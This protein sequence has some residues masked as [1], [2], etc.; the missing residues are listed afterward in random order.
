MNTT[1]GIVQ[2]LN[3]WT[4]LQHQ[5]NIKT[6]KTSTYPTRA[7]THRNRWYD[8]FS[9]KIAFWVSLQRGIIQ[10][11]SFAHFLFQNVIFFII[12]DGMTGNGREFPFSRFCVE[13]FALFLK[14]SKIIKRRDQMKC[15]KWWRRFVKR[16]PDLESNFPKRDMI[17]RQIVFHSFNK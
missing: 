11:I 5:N 15:W 13:N 9:D 16:V 17:D 4:K 2:I 3:V 10:V 14:K 12:T 7:R 8:T 6:K 1:L